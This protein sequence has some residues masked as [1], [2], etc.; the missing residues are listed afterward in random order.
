MF[1]KSLHLAL[2]IIILSLGLELIGQS[3]SYPPSKQEVVIDKYHGHQIA[4]PFRWLEDTESADVQAWMH[5]QDQFLKNYISDPQQFQRIQ[6]RI[7]ALEK[8]GTNHSVPQKAGGKYY[9]N[10]WPREL[11]HALLHQRSGLDG[12]SKVIV[13]LNKILQQ[14]KLTYNGFSVSPNGKYLALLI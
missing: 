4:D 2:P 6:S 12:V 9:Y 1:K 8:T 7:E 5:A 14:D 11:R 10:T 3:L 13:D